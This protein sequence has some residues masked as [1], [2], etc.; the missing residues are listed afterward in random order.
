[1]NYVKAY[2][3]K[4]LIVPNVYPCFRAMSNFFNNVNSGR[5]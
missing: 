2:C 5:T 1:M 3:N 4:Y